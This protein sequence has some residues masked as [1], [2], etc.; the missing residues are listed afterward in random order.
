MT[1]PSRPPSKL[2]SSDNKWSSIKPRKSARRN[3]QLFSSSRLCGISFLSPVYLKNDLLRKRA[4]NVAFAYSQP[5]EKAASRRKKRKKRGVKSGLRM[6][7]TDNISNRY[8]NDDDE[9]RDNSSPFNKGKTK[10][11]QKCNTNVYWGIRSKTAHGSFGKV[12]GCGIGSLKLANLFQIGDPTRPKRA[13]ASDE[14]RCASRWR[15][16]MAT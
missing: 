9:D 4:E 5:N 1:R 16:P 8:G 6:L 14:D 13:M 11:R 7:E 2:P 10:L 3:P 12:I 15:L